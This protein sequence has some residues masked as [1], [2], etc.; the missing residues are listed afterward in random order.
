MKL[1][2]SEVDKFLIRYFASSL[3]NSNMNQFNK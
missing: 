2:N 3:D 1:A